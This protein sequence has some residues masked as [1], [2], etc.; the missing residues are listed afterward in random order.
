MIDTTSE[1]SKN[2]V[3]RLR[4]ENLN[5]KIMLNRYLPPNSSTRKRR[6]VGGFS[7]IFKN[8]QDSS[9]E[10]APLGI[11]YAVD[12]SRKGREFIKL[13]STIL[14][15]REHLRKFE[16]L[17]HRT[18]NV[19]KPVNQE[20]APNY[21]C[22]VFP[23]SIID[24]SIETSDNLDSEMNLD[25][26]VKEADRITRREEI[27]YSANDDLLINTDS[28]KT[29]QDKEREEAEERRKEYF[30][31]K[32]KCFNCGAT[33]HKKQ[34]C[35]LPN[36]PRMVAENYNRLRFLEAFLEKHDLKE[37]KKD[38]KD[39][40]DNTLAGAFQ[41]EN[42]NFGSQK[43]RRT[44]KTF[45]QSRPIDTTFSPGGNLSAELREALGLES[46]N[47]IPKHVLNMRKLGYPTGW[48]RHIRVKETKPL[49]IQIDETEKLPPGAKFQQQ[50][51]KQL[52]KIEEDLNQK[53]KKTLDLDDG[54][55]LSS[56]EEQ[57]IETTKKA[58]EALQF[59]SLFT[60]DYDNLNVYPGFNVKI[61]KSP[62]LDEELDQNNRPPSR[63]SSKQS[64]NEDGELSDDDEEIIEIPEE[65]NP[66]NH[67]ANMRKYLHKV[68]LKVAEKLGRSNE[69]GDLVKWEEFYQNN[70]SVI[71]SEDDD[72]MS[73]E[74]N[75]KTDITEEPRVFSIVTSK[76]DEEK[77]R[78]SEKGL[79]RLANFSM[80]VAPFERNY[81]DESLV[82][83]GTFK[84]I[85]KLLNK[86]KNQ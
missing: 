45:D 18:E 79:P 5:L 73:D 41:N 55:V 59:S 53:V 20:T 57:L 28:S 35:P 31:L 61:E 47:D 83:K 44:E 75:E 27:R 8:S 76:D 72:E 67:I 10:N 3:E 65:Y 77:H 34:D 66:E 60:F 33:T 21:I 36:N 46:P 63:K 23:H 29:R 85:N 42:P 7:S 12:N 32:K 22:H 51:K 37:K 43:R 49:S 40:A 13:V 69:I 19:P 30:E 24:K 16:D 86:Y 54:E 1:E 81:I 71:E 50:N 52:D 39:N 38:A 11:I 9:S 14:N 26:M 4:E 15:R 6:R 56:D 62:N 48:L 25:D 58:Q 68:N 80:G 64:S 84:K 70:D 17:Q 78:N 82:K 2:E 74:I